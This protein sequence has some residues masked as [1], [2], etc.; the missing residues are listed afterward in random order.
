MFKKLTMWCLAASLMMPLA[1]VS[2]VPAAQAKSFT[3]FEQD[4]KPKPTP[5]PR[6]PRPK[7][8]PRDGGDDN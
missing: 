3:L 1:I 4:G 5:D 8:G 2:E 6:G 7:P